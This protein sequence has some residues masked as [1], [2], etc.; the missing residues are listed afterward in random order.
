MYGWASICA[1][2]KQADRL[3]FNGGEDRETKHPGSV[4]PR[5]L[6]PIA[7]SR[8]IITTYGYKSKHLFP[9]I[10][11][12]RRNTW[13]AKGAAIT[14]KDAQPRWQDSLTQA[15]LTIDC[16]IQIFFVEICP[17]LGGNTNALLSFLR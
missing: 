4:R 6:W 14:P 2:R 16:E 5:Q 12:F 11:F 3:N 9:N 8:P 13:P 10:A 15:L 7:F 17:S 1:H